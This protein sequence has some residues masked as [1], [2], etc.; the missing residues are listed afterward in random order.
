M[1]I[2]GINPA[3]PGLLPNA[4]KL[5]ANEQRLLNLRNI[6][7]IASRAESIFNYLNINCPDR[8]SLIMDIESTHEICPLDLDA[9]H[10]ADEGN[11]IHDI[12]GILQH[13]NRVTKK[14][15]GG[16]VPRF[17]LRP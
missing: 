10:N 8:I 16:F 12:G 2:N 9:L 14:L 6:A 15:D 5:P 7:R 11:F 3:Q 4:V 13:F 1:E 17:A